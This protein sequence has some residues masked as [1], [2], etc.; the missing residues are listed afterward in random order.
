[1]KR[2]ASVSYGNT[3]GINFSFEVLAKNDYGR[4]IS[5]INALDTNN[6]GYS[7]LVVITAGDENTYSAKMYF[8]GGAKKV[9][10]TAPS[11]SLDLKSDNFHFVEASVD[12]GNLMGDGNGDKTIVIGGR[13]NGERHCI[14]YIK[15]YPEENGYD[16]ALPKLH[17]MESETNTVFEAIV[18][19][20]HNIKCVSLET[21]NDSKPEYVVFGGYIFVYDKDNKKFIRKKIDNYYQIG[22]ASRANTDDTAESNI[23][24]V[25]KY[26]DEGIII[27]T[28]VGNFN[29]NTE[30]KEQIIMLHYNEW[31]SHDDYIYLTQCYMDDDGKII[32]NLNQVFHRKDGDRNKKSPLYATICAVDVLNHGVKMEFVPEKSVFTYSDPVIV[33]VMGTSPWFEEIEDEYGDVLGNIETVIDKS[34]SEENSYGLSV[35]VTTGAI[36]GFEEEVSAFG[37]SVGSVEFEA[38]VKNS[39]TSGWEKSTSFTTGISYVNYYA[40]DA[41][42]VSIIPYDIYYYN[43]TVWDGNKYVKGSTT[44]V[45]PNKPITTM[46]PVEKYNS[47]AAAI[48][49]APIISDDVLCHTVGDPRTYPQS[50][51]DL[52]NAYN[53]VMK[54]KNEN[55]AFQSSGI[56]GNSQ[57]QNI[58][59]TVETKGTV[60]FTNEIETSLKVTLLGASAG[61]VAGRSES[62]GITLASSDSTVYTGQAACVPD[63]LEQY[64]V[65]WAL[66]VYNSK[67]YSKSGKYVQD[68]PVVNYLCR[69]M[70][71]NSYSGKDNYPPKVPQNL[72]VKSQDAAGTTLC[73]DKVN[74]A[75]GYIIYRYD[76][77]MGNPEVFRVSGVNTTIYNDT[78]R[79][80]G[81]NY[82]YAVAAYKNNL[83]SVPC[84]PLLVPA[85]AVKNLKIKQQPKLTYKEYEA[86]D[87]SNLV[88][89]LVMDNGAE[90][91]VNYADLE[92]YS[93]SVDM[94]D[95][96][97]LDASYN[98][99]PL[100]VKYEPTGLTV[101]T[102][103][104]NVKEIGEYPLLMDVKFHA[105][106][107]QIVSY[108]IPGQRLSALVNL[109]NTTDSDI[110]AVVI[111]A[112][113][114]R[115]MTMV[116]YDEK[117]VTIAAGGSDNQYCSV[118]LPSDVSG[119]IAKVFVW[120]GSG[121]T[122]SNLIP[123]SDTVQIPY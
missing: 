97:E 73:W 53:I 107:N 35:S 114:N 95:G 18:N 96:I 118:M 67:L 62:T 99:T 29:S 71:S 113:Y 112:L 68:C 33:A 78:A 9:D 27:D 11:Y 85:L 101:Y 56:D 115:D 5:S 47:I 70:S 105:G 64:Q 123:L 49:N 122:D 83:Y 8:Y 4:P 75:S 19:N 32:S 63:G 41:V 60:E 54:T 39:F 13:T 7:E 46:M 26:K 22:D 121:I 116:T 93:L 24:S 31:W 40:Q 89:T 23:T 2:P 94:N 51:K 34:T 48:D 79:K 90:M 81:K 15:Y 1:M 30:G 80:L 16:N 110:T 106:G 45:I 103:K 77:N 38:Q 82:N 36:L 66:A 111:L 84:E 50:K 120:D 91:D 57:R 108:L 59:N 104:L 76:E 14:T 3:S 102:N 74:D 17:I 42:V 6:D 21:P 98:G 72:S 100:A 86:L 69:P 119:F 92:K 88:V 37:V 28:I 58:G 61:I 10:L 87:L 43:T 44:L 117:T 12:I 109:E 25:N 52:R 55:D 20:D 65:N